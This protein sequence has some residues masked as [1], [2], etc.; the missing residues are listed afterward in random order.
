M[1]VLREI[2]ESGEKLCMDCLK[3]TWNYVFVYS[4]IDC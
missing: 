2:K 3:S 1:M 4:V